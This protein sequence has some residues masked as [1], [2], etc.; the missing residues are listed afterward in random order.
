MKELASKKGTSLRVPSSTALSSSVEPKQ[1]RRNYE[2][3]KSPPPVIISFSNI[4]K[5]A[6]KGS[7]LDFIGHFPDAF[8]SGVSRS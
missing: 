2:V 3:L 7:C 8:D 5:R 1:I 6:G 4:V